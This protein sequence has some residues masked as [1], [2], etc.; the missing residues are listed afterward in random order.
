MFT[1]WKR[2]FL[3]FQNQQIYWYSRELHLLYAGSELYNWMLTAVIWTVKISIRFHSSVP[4][5]CVCLCMSPADCALNPLDR[6]MCSV[7]DVWVAEIPLCTIVPVSPGVRTRHNCS[8]C[9]SATL[10]VIIN[11]SHN[12]WRFVIL[13]HISH[14]SHPGSSTLDVRPM[15]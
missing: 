7:S 5:P 1:R 6:P 8:H 3:N 2:T 9:I 15:F 11:C 12:N 10:C 4:Q 14:S 13:A